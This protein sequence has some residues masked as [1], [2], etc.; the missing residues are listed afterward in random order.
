VERAEKALHENRR[1]LALQRLASVWANA[2]AIAYSQSRPA[3]EHTDESRFEAEWKRVGGVLHADRATAA[4]SAFSNLQPA[5][6]RA[7]AEV[8]QPQIGVFYDASVV[9]SRSDSPESGLFYVG[10][11]LAQKDFLAVCKRLSAPASGAAPRLRSL[12][13][14]IESLQNELLA[15]YKP[16]ASIDRHDEF[17]LGNSLIKE[18]RDLDAAGLR[19]GALLRYLLAALRTGSLRSP[20]AKFAPD[21][22]NARLREFDA[23]LSDRSLDHSIGRIFLEAA[24]SEIDAAPATAPASAVTVASDVLP[25]YF[26]AL[27][28]ARPAP[29]KPAPKVTVTL[30]RWPYT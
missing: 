22:L 25:R 5:A 17:I 15:A 7:V 8:A 1:L 14:D 16:P 10:S 23:R 2:G 9:Y 26:A 27:E 20:D 4:P 21:V 6:L 11:A 24:Q 28:P 19:E 30:V 12:A 13:P 3:V 29:A 18:A